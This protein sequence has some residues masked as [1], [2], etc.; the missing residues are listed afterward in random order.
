MRHSNKRSFLKSAILIL[1]IAAAAV[2]LPA[3][4]EKT[5]PAETESSVTQQVEITITVEVVG[6]DGTAKEYAVTTD[7]DNLEGALLDSGFVS[8]EEGPYGLYI[9][10][11]CG[12]TADYDTDG[13]YWSILKNGEYL[14]TGAGDTPIA[15]DEHYELVYTK[16]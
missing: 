2:T 13:A 10:T 7:S 6:P 16:G 15:A 11:V 4:G 8:G 3:C 12:I 5:P 9:K 14:M 1:L